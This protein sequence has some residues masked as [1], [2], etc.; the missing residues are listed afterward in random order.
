MVCP[1]SY[2]RNQDLA[3]QNHFKWL[4]NSESFFINPIILYH[5]L[6]LLLKFN[7]L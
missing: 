2:L 1:K 5:L 6:V 7:S 3:L 4:V